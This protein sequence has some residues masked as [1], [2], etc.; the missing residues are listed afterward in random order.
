MRRLCIKHRWLGRGLRAIE[1]SG[2]K[3]HCETARAMALAIKQPV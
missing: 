3:Q 2:G 1:L